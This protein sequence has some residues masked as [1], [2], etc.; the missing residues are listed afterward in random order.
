ML[1]G[2]F[3]TSSTSSLSNSMDWFLYDKDLRHERVKQ[4]ALHSLFVN[5]YLAALFYLCTMIKL[6]LKQQIKVAQ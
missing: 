6:Q 4:E 3:L 2:M 5:M 1:E